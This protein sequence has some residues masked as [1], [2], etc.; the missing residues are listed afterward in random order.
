MNVS[1]LDLSA[2]SGKVIKF[3][4]DKVCQSV[5]YRWIVFDRLFRGVVAKKYGNKEYIPLGLYVLIGR[6]RA[7]WRSQCQTV[8]GPSKA[9]HG[10]NPSSNIWGEPEGGVGS[11]EGIPKAGPAGLTTRTAWERC[12]DFE[13]SKDSLIYEKSLL[14]PGEE[15]RIRRLLS[16]NFNIL[17]QV[18]CCYWAAHSASCLAEELLS[19]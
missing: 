18:I 7:A 4:S 1:V 10:G 15:Q 17:S 12:C 5:W 3:V 19:F 8:R 14:V 11:W 6:L 9:V 16:S 13:K 2:T